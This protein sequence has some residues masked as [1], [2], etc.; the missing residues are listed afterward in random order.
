MKNMP[1]LRS[2]LRPEFVESKLN[3]THSLAGSFVTKQA[4]GFNVSHF[5]KQDTLKLSVSLPRD[6]F[7]K[8]MARV[9]FNKGG[10]QNE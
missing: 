1:P 6:A 3:Y 10:K 7:F 8:W 5:T 2:Y 9:Q 4:K